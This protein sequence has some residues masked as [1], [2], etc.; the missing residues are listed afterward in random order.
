MRTRLN[1]YRATFMFLVA[2]FLLLV[3]PGCDFQGDSLDDLIEWINA[4]NGTGVVVQDT[5][6]DP[7]TCDDLMFPSGP[8]FISGAMEWDFPIDPDSVYWYTGGFSS[9]S[10][11]SVI[12]YAAASMGVVVDSLDTWGTEDGFGF[13]L[14]G[15]KNHTPWLLKVWTRQSSASG[16][17]TA[18]GPE[19]VHVAYDSRTSAKWYMPANSMALLFGKM[20][21]FAQL[22][23]AAL[24]HKNAEWWNMRNIEATPVECMEIAEIM[25]G[26][27][28]HGRK[29]AD[30]RWGTFE[31]FIYGYF[32]N[33]E[34]D[35]VLTP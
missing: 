14:N 10:L 7:A 3:P 26:E 27:C 8:L 29:W 19:A 30:F 11:D 5:I 24:G 33:A 35:E 23:N 12:R 4:N 34:W 6:V 2:F 25:L 28:I 32:E 16:G 15:T 31:P 20:V 9:Y 17:F 22:R 18:S 21:T 1:F 13:L